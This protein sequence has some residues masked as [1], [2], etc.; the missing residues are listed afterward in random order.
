MLILIYPT[1]YIL[2]PQTKQQHKH[3]VYLTDSIYMCRSGKISLTHSLQQHFLKTKQR[4]DFLPIE[5]GGGKLPEHW[6]KG[7]N[8]NCIETNG[9]FKRVASLGPYASFRWAAARRD[10]SRLQRSRG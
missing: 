1:G 9:A 2:N 5:L 7:S 4:L 8:C 10:A 3:I 6:S